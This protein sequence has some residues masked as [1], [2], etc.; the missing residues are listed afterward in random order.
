MTDK[1]PANTLTV[2]S[3]PGKNVQ[4]V[5]WRV[6][7]FGDRVIEEVN[8]VAFDKL[9]ARA[10]LHGLFGDRLSRPDTLYIVAGSDSGQ[11]VRHVCEHTP[12]PGTRYLFV[13]PPVIHGALADAGLLQ[14]LPDQVRCA[15]A[16]AWAE[17]ARAL[18][19]EEYLYIDGVELV[20]SLAA[21]STDANEYVKLAWEMRDTLHAL[22]WQTAAVR[23][24]EAFIA[25]Q[26]EN[27]ADNVEPAGLWRG[28]LA[29]KTG[30]L[31][32]GGPSLD[33]ALEW[34]RQHR[35]GLVVVAVSRISRRL[36]EAGIEPDFVV[37]VDPTE[38]SYEI[39]RDMLRFGASV[40]FIH[41]YH[42]VPRLLGQWPHR[43]FYLGPLLPWP[44]PLNPREP[45]QAVGPTVTNTAL[46]FAGA[47]GLSRVILAGVD[48]CFTPEGHT[49]AQ[50]SNE[51]RAGPR[52]DL[53][54]LEVETNDGRRASTTAD[55][56]SAIQTLGLQVQHWRSRG[57]EILNP[58]GGAA[59]IP[60]VEHRSLH[61]LPI[62]DQPVARPLRTA[63]ACDTPACRLQHAQRVLRELQRTLGALDDLSGNLRHARR[64]VDKL[65]EA[66]GTIHNRNLRK[67]LDRLEAEL[68]ER[69]PD[70]SAL[71][72]RCSTHALL[73]A[74]KST[75]D[76]ETLDAAAVREALAAYYDAY[77]DGANRLRGMLERGIEKARL[78]VREYDGSTPLR[79]LAPKW[80][81]QRET[82]RFVRWQLN[83]STAPSSPEEAQT[84]ND[85]RAIWEADLRNQEGQHMV[86][87]R[88]QADLRAARIRLEDLFA[89]GKA[90]GIRGV[91]AGLEQVPD[92][93][94]AA[95]YL[96]LARGLLAE[97]E[98]RIDDALGHYDAV[99]QT[100]QRHLW[101]TALQRVAAWALQHG[102]PEH[103]RQSLECLAALAPRYRMPYADLLAA[104]GDITGAIDVYEAHLAEHPS[105]THAL[106][107]LARLA[108]NA[109][110]QDAATVLIEQMKRLPGGDTVAAALHQL[111]CGNPKPT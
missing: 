32:A 74:M 17:A 80:V 61:E 59:R 7:A 37:S 40:S 84:M 104:M 13:D 93:T 14:G 55:F 105:D 63:D 78:R 5:T 29:G 108:L 76:I 102:Q 28:V 39:S 68:G 109:G 72:R 75:R 4:P 52:F 60:G 1:S 92:P 101:P 98:G 34:V 6:N 21:Q 58:A 99:L 56:L 53:T 107:R 94:A 44:S 69:Y 67:R 97:L 42:V 8:G 12:P 85:L 79:A 20:L 48:L 88:S 30:V 22:R 50:G 71:I 106:A 19:I 9:G 62:P 64:I 100:D 15:P 86:R 45:L 54:G 43:S 26:L 27:A 65:F 57:M 91:M 46:A 51:R 25:C 11:L 77:L 35:N 95:P 111:M 36:L 103:A 82:G 83:H 110:D 31:L 96:A 24:T 33:D 18:Q 81:A 47:V 3:L 38:M 41:Q 2:D 16:D 23:G 49:H 89:Q 73:R 10:T 90:D 70:L 66:D 87:V